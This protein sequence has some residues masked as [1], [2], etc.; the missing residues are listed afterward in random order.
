MKGFV[1]DLDNTLYDRYG[2]I[3]EFI[4]LGWDRVEKYINPAYDFEKAVTHICR[5]EA[6]Y[7]YKGWE[8]IYEHLV[9][10]C[11]FNFNNIPSF[12]KVR[13]FALNGF[14]NVAIPHPFTNNIL[15]KLKDKGY[16]LGLITNAA[17]REYQYTK[18]N[19][20]DICDYFDAIVVTGDLSLQQCGRNDNREYYKPNPAV[21]EH[22]SNLLGEKPE[23]LY[24]VGDNEYMD[25]VG[26]LN[27]GYTPIWIKSQSP[28]RIKDMPMPEYSFDTIEGI[29][30]II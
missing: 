5:I 2:T 8:T 10:E 13:D 16:K 18:M 12:E 11:F 17:S 21:F 7:I 29:L 23:Q 26:A 4:K 14:K 30:D 1:F 3:R 27:S 20:L 22:M 9:D 15:K 6:I 24:Y 25:V 28:W 19:M